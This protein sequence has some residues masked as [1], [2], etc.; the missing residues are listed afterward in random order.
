[1]FNQPELLTLKIVS[2][3]KRM[4]WA[5]LGKALKLLYPDLT[6]AELTLPLALLVLLHFVLKQQ[7]STSKRENN[8]ESH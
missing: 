2:S 6:G 1:M 5:K 4:S 3:Q 8:L 7:Q